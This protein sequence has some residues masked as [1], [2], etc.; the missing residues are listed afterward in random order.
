MAPKDGFP[1]RTHDGREESPSHRPPRTSTALEPL[2]ATDTTVGTMP[3]S[4][5]SDDDGDGDDGDDLDSEAGPAVMAVCRSPKDLLSSQLRR[6]RR[7]RATTRLGGGARAAPVVLQQR[8]RS[9]GVCVMCVMCVMC[10]M[11]VMCDV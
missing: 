4:S 9:V 5:S 2:L 1:P 3:R 10:A 7:V 8:G 11:C 6:N